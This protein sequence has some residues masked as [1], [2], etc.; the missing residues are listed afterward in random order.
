[1][2][3]Y[4]N[5]KHEIKALYNSTNKNLKEIEIDRDEYFGGFTDFMMLN[6]CYKEFEDGYSIY[7]AFNYNELISQDNQMKIDE[8]RE[9][10][11]LLKQENELQEEIIANLTYDLMVMQYT[12]S[13][14]VKTLN[15]K[16][17]SKF[18]IIKKWFIMGFWTEEM[19]QN[20]ANLNQITQEECE[21]ILDESLNEN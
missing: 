13:D 12:K 3:I 10:I 19:V 1:M 15:T 5:D 11:K 4:I 18:I 17:S 7:P 8:S 20:A 16:Q 9:D 14:E 2:K 21:S 6:Y